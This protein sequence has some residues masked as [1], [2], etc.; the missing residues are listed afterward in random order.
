MYCSY[1]RKIGFKAV[2]T[3]AVAR[4]NPEVRAE[5]DSGWRRG[6]LDQTQVGEAGALGGWGVLLRTET[7]EREKGDGVAE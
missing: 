2:K 6:V 5:R 1:D 3:V 7:F 4:R